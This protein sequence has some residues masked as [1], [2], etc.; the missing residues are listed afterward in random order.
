MT[1]RILSDLEQG[2]EEWF[3]ARRG[4]VTASTVGS[5]LSVRKPGATE[6][7]CPTCEALAGEPCLSLRKT[8]GDGPIKADAASIKTMHP[9]R[10]AYAAADT[11]SPLIVEPANGKDAYSLTALLTAE[12]I[13]GYTEDTYTTFDMLRG[14]EVEPL[15]VDTYSQHFAKVETVGLMVRDDW[16]FS[17]GFS[18]DGLVGEDGLV[19]IKAP[20]QKGHLATVLGNRVPAD[21]MAQ[22]QCGL[23][24]SGRKWIDFISYCGGL[25]LWVQRVYPDPAW[26]AAIIAAVE[27][28]ET[29]SAE[30]VAKYNAATADLPLTERVDFDDVELKL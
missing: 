7:D 18:P 12:R 8:K 29:T 22:L 20:R 28:F 23:L 10:V 14:H 4:M 11:S 19:E 24:V 1:L 21:H 25:R 27:T 26:H 13:S 5:L 6:Y 16:G 9:D 30:M 17:I 3:A 15:A 2:T